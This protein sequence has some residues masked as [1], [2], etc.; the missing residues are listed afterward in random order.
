MKIIY[1]AL[2]TFT[3][4]AHQLAAQLSYKTRGSTICVKDPLSPLMLYT[5]GP[6]TIIP[7]EDGQ[8]LEV[9][10]TYSIIAIPEPDYTFTSWNPVEVFTLT[11]IVLDT[12]SDPGTVITNTITSVTLSAVPRYIGAQSL[13][14]TMEPEEVLYSSNGNTLTRS[15]GWQANFVPLISSDLR[16]RRDPDES[17]TN[18]IR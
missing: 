2:L 3:L 11:S 15:V 5:N 16:R 8:M 13:R 12:I 17:L 1:L 14:F 10:R 18:A 6:G 7:F 4:A 9:G